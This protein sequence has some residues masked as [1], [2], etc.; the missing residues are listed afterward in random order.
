MAVWRNLPQ[1]SEE[2]R[3]QCHHMWAM[4]IITQTGKTHIT[5]YNMSRMLRYNTIFVLDIYL[6]FEIA[7]MTPYFIHLYL[8]K[9][10]TCFSTLIY[11]VKTPTSVSV[12]T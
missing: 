8:S 12:L 2:M 9:L 4:Q 3:V 11:F 10:Q 7:S 1:M 6:G 5:D